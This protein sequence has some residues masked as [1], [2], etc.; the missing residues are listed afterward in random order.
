M[1]GLFGAIMVSSIGPVLE[2]VSGVRLPGAGAGPTPLSL[3]G[4]DAARS[5]YDAPTIAIFVFLSGTLTTLLVHW[6]SD[7]HTRRAPAW[8]CGFPDASPATQYTA[9]SFSQPLRRVYGSTVFSAR[10]IVDMPAPG[11]IRAARLVVAQSD[12]IW[13]WL[14]EAPARLVQRVAE[15]LNAL[16]FLSV[17]R[18]LVLMFLA[19]IVLLL[20]TAARG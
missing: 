9:S 1:G 11:E 7:R 20:V 10:E 6:I 16:Q 3:V 8:D 17:R 2:Q 18:Y 14:Y 19:L 15:R 12:H 5:T 13:Q 4:F